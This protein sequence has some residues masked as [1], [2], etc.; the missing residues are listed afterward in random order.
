MPSAL[1]ARV[2]IAFSSTV[3]RHLESLAPHLNAAAY[4][5]RGTVHADLV[6]SS[7]VQRVTVRQEGRSTSTAIFR[8]SGRHSFWDHD[9]RAWVDFPQPGPRLQIQ[10]PKSLK[11]KTVAKQKSAVV[12]MEI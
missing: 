3:S 1:K 7:N 9:L 5:P 10:P 2:T 12:E 6:T 8:S 4:T 11:V